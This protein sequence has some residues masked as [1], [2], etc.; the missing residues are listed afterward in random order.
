[1]VTEILPA[2]Q[3]LGQ[4]K[5]KNKLMPWSIAELLGQDYSQWAAGLTSATGKLIDRIFN[6]LGST[7]NP[8][9]LLNAET[10]LNSVKGRVS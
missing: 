2:V 7:S 8:A 9:A 4:F 6:T 5:T 3:G 1:M 10:Y